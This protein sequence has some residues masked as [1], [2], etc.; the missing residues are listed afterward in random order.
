MT[1]I[2]SGCAPFRQAAH[3]PQGSEEPEPPGETRTLSGLNCSPKIIMMM[4]IHVY[5]THVGHWH[6]VLN[7]H[8]HSHVATHD[9][10]NEVLLYSPVC[11]HT[12]ICA[13]VEFG[14]GAPVGCSRRT[15]SQRVPPMCAQVTRHGELKIADFGLAS[16]RYSLPS[17][18]AV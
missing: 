7:H 17:T 10:P 16:V 18:W 8:P 2:T 5:L 3:R 4:M 12:R 14:F 9:R 11:G 6:I 1:L 15:Q 13:P